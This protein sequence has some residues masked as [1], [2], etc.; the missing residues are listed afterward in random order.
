MCAP[1][2]TRHTSIR[3]SSSPAVNGRPHD[4]Y[5]HR[6]PV[7]VYCLYHTRMVL[8]VGGSF[9]VLCTKC[10]LHS[11]HRFTRVIFQHTERLLPRNGHF[12]ATYTRIAWRQKCELRWKT[13][14]WEN[15]FFS[16]SFCLYRFRKHVSYGSPI[17]NFWNHGL[18]FETPC[19]IIKTVLSN[20][21]S[22]NFH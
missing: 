16:C 2:V 12:L 1:G 21:Y 5:L 8:S 22:F 14:Y 11:N 18:H 15:F 10:T 19:I 7:P 6:H 20:A 9:C 17:I 4:F 13:T 3:Y